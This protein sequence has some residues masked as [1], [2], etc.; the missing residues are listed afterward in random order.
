MG[1]QVELPRE[2]EPAASIADAPEPQQQDIPKSN[3]S[4]KE[5]EN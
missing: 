1:C 3:D 4:G 2:H 5:L